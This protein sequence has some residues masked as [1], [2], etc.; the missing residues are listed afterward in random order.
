[1]KKV[2][3]LA[4]V[5]I[6]LFAAKATQ[7]Q[8]F[9]LQG[10]YWDY[11]KTSQNAFW[12]DTM[13]AHA[14]EWS[15]A[16][17]TTV[18]CPPM[19]MAASGNGSNG[20]DIKDLF[21]LGG[22][23]NAN[24]GFGNRTKI[25]S[26]ISTFNQYNLKAVADMVYNHRNGGQPETNDAVAGWIKN[27]NITKHNSGDACFP[28]D[29]FR[30]V[31]TIGG[32]TGRGAGTYYFRI[33]SA[34]QSADYYGKP[35]TFYVRTVRKNN[36]PAPAMTET[37]SNGG[38]LCGEGND[39]IGLARITNA[40]IDNGG[41]GIDEFR[42]VLDT[43]QF[44][45]AGDQ[46][47]FSMANDNGNYADQYV[48]SLYYDAT[49]AELKDS[50]AYQTYTNFGS[51]PSG[52]GQMHKECFKPN[53]NPTCLCGDW[54]AIMFFNDYDQA[55]QKTKDTLFTWTKWMWDSIG[56][57]GI[58]ADAVKNYSYQFTAEMLNYLNAN[59][60]AP[61]VFVGEFYDYNP[62]ALK[63]WVDNVKANMNAAALQN[64]QPRVFDFALQGAIKE[65]CDNIGGY[66]TRNIFQSGMVD[67][68][69]ASGF[70][71]VTFVN[72][73]DFRTAAQAIDVDPIL[74][75]AYLLT[76]NTIGL[77]CV[78]YPD[79][80]L[81]NGAYKTKIDELMD[82]HR[83][84]IYNTGFKEYLNRFNTPF[85][86]NYISGSAD[87]CL[88]YQLSGGGNASCIAN[89]DVIVA[90]NYGNTTLKVDQQINTGGVFHSSIGDTLLD[91]LGNSNYPYAIVNGS[92]QMYVEL[93]ARS[94]SVWINVQQPVTPTIAIT[95]SATFCKGD[96]VT[97]TANT[98]SSC[99]T[100][101][102][103]LNGVVIDGATKNKFVAKQSGTY[104]VTVSYYGNFAH[105]SMPVLI[106]VLP[107]QP[108][109]SANGNTLSSSAASSYQWYYSLD[110]INY[111]LIAGAT[112][113]N[114]FTATHGWYKVMI[115]DANG[116]SDTS[117]AYHLE[118]AGIKNLN[119]DF[120]F[121]V[122]PNPANDVLNI[123]ITSKKIGNY[124]IEMVNTV[125]QTVFSNNYVANSSTSFQTS[126]KLNA[127][128]AG[129]YFVK[130]GD[131]NGFNVMRFVKE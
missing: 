131:G 77:P 126:I 95:G 10:W 120:N 91:V 7:A 110:S 35:Y 76:N 101:Q 114:Y 112:S 3:V 79:Y 54:D 33:R 92:G 31:L 4:Y 128:P 62:A 41:C 127:L 24:T 37:V 21:N 86:S 129:V 111:T 59:A 9:M 98:A 55:V 107:L 73:H 69:G 47:I 97:L 108:V 99:Y 85:S 72:N 102:W 68:A 64:I 57:R 70:N 124:K 65:A 66:D 12:V 117:A 28:S 90:I 40:T 58:R 19:S 16:G 51:M 17:F 56:V 45:A 60:I 36:N 20:Y 18:W 38:V 48:Y 53:G 100:F 11:P 88:I 23:G 105:T 1:M 27:Y 116:C 125:G 30:C 32:T 67:G 29:R 42:L 122:A 75:Y 84:F 61:P 80:Y 46:L 83:K 96:S 74:A 8:D 81:N 34:S 119:P 13:T 89:K 130:V 82:V 2:I 93:P 39:S 71:A 78:Y 6:S 123:S 121:T 52:R 49:A 104:T 106:T 115:T 14:K 50:V 15:D 103:K 5:C 63:G 44:Y 109:I 113:Q 22:I 26:M 87:K 25:Q 94:Y 118:F 43:S